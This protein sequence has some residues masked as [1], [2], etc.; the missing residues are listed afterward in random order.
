L[1]GRVLVEFAPPGVGLLSQ[2]STVIGVAHQ[3]TV[4][5]PWRSGFRLRSIE[6]DPLFVLDDATLGRL[7]VGRLAY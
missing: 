3:W 7:G 5:V 4:G 2:D 1:G 6:S